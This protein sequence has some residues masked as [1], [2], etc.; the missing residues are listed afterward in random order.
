MPIEDHPAWLLGLFEYLGERVR[1]PNGCDHTL[2]HAEKFLANCD[3]CDDIV[4]AREWLAGHNGHCDCEIMWN[5][6][7]WARNDAGIVD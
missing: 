5:V 2:R 7:D 3:D 4:A 6:M 1:E